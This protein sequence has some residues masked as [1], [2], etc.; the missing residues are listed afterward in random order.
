M[1]AALCFRVEIFGYSRNSEPRISERNCVGDVGKCAFC[2]MT[3]DSHKAQNYHISRKQIRGN[4]C[5]GAMCFLREDIRIATRARNSHI[6]RTQ[7]WA[8]WG[9]CAC[10]G[11][12]LGF[13][14]KSQI[15]HIP[16]TLF[17]GN[18]GS[19]VF[20]RGD[21][22]VVAKRKIPTSPNTIAGI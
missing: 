14:R 19:L 9:Q 5:V 6:R 20:L 2:G 15:S 17:W 8:M 11:E 13:S 16:R 22:L 7:L 4:V 10:F 1:W 12:T 18:A 21:L 3:P